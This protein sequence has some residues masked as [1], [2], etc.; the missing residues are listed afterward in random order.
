M[1]DPNQMK[2]TSEGKEKLEAELHLFKTEKRK[3]VAEKI[4]AAK[5]M[6]DISENAEYAAAKDEQAFLEARI[7]ELETILAY[8]QVVDHQ[9]VGESVNIGTTVKLRTDG[10][11]MREYTIVG[12]NEANPSDGKISN[13]SPLGQALV[14]K[15]V[16][17]TVV[18]KAPSGEKKFTVISIT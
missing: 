15:K 8:A 1:T 4:E 6:G 14:G 2:L 7:T 17:D 11:E 12:Y 3:Q 9:A 18:I 10:G 13:E 16:N 5:E